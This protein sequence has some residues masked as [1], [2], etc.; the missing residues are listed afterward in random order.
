MYKEAHQ[1]L[2]IENGKELIENCT[3]SKLN[4]VAFFTY[5][6]WCELVC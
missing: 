3:L 2:K 4:K 1:T 5:T 6:L